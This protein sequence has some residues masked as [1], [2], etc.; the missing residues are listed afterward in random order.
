M[1]ADSDQS[2]LP[3]RRLAE[4]LRDFRERKQLTQKQLAT[5]IGGADALSVATISQWENPGS[6]RLPPSQ[7]LAAY[8]RLFCTGRS[9]GSGVPRL[10]DDDELTEQEREREGELYAELLGLRER[11]QLAVT[12]A[13]PALAGPPRS[14]WHFPDGRAVSIVCSDAPDELQ[15]EYA[16]PSHLNYTRYARHADLDALIEVFGQVKAENPGTTV[17]ILPDEHLQYDLAL[18]HLV[19][20]GGAAVRA[21]VKSYG[22]TGH[23]TKDL[24]LP[25]AE[26]I[27]GTDTHIFR[28]GGEAGGFTSILDTDRNVV[29]DVGLIARG[30]HPSAPSK[31]VIVLS[32][33]TS[34][35]VH[36]AALCFTDPHVSDINEQY[37]RDA[38]G[39][40]D[41]F[42][43]L[44]V[45]HV[46]NGAALPPNLSDPDVR[47]YEWS[48]ATGER[49]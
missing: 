29:E 6:G 33:I 8:A 44:M 2:P 28:V 19:I 27:Q 31:N 45:V 13:V 37:V 47:L 23:F 46:R 9:F 17:R 15:P 49:W 16:K 42:C 7:R 40:T 35:G 24:I 38:F 36:G 26:P 3:A 14:L 12:V 41:A 1:V 43:M 10:L 20:I 34:R 11:A 5:A 18:N 22:H 39:S 25:K 4:R 32:G 21:A 30:R 48:A